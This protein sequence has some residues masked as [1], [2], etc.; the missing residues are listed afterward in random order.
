MLNFK[1]QCTMKKPVVLLFSLLFA[2]ANIFAQG[3]KTEM[4]KAQKSGKS[5]YLIVTDKSATDTDV[6]EKMVNDAL[7]KTS[8]TVKIKLY[9]DDKDNSNLITKYRLSFATLPL[10]L[11][12]AS[13]GVVSGGLTT[14]DATV[15]KLISYLPT[16]KQAEVLLGFEN[17]K[18]AFIVCGKK[19]DKDKASLEKEC[20]TAIE[21]LGNN[22]NMFFVDVN[23]KEEANFLALLKPDLTKTTVLVFNGRGQY[24]GTLE[25]SAKSKDLIA[26]VN[27]KIGGGCCSGGNSGSCG[28][29]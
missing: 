26:L 7:K 8:N 21:G 16:K 15:E 9:R 1:Y 13:N 6:L 29:K 18:A 23:S 19:N 2:T 14:K 27:K 24:T 20:K 4:E 11:V 25:A 22:A 12:L 10:V 5:I 3:A 28:K 17:G